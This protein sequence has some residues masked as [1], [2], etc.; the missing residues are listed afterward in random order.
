LI[1]KSIG[2]PKFGNLVFF[3][4]FGNDG[5]LKSNHKSTRRILTSEE[6]GITASRFS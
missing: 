5:I 3:P 1:G 6:N 2:V 4:V